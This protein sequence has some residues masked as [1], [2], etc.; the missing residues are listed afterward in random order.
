MGNLFSKARDWLPAQVDRAAGETV[1]YSRA[2]E[3]LTV[4]AVVGQVLASEAEEGAARIAYTDRDYLIAVAALRA[5]FGRPRVGDT[6][7]HEIDGE[8]IVF[9]VQ[10][11]DGAEQAVRFADQTRFT[12]RIHVK[13]KEE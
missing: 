12:W 11:L 5:T 13:R 2:G 3:S 1:V 4:T 6:I 9:V 7:T 10:N 8:E